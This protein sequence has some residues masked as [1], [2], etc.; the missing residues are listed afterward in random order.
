MGASHQQTRHFNDAMIHYHPYLE[1]AHDDGNLRAGCDE[2]EEDTHQE[3]E[4][5][6][7]LMEPQSRHD[8]E[9]LDADGAE[10]QDAAQGN[11]EEGVSIPHLLRN[12]P[13]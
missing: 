3:A 2:D 11:G 4:D 1:V 6:V 9:Q 5:V 7:N 13:E 12:V 10:G 8:K